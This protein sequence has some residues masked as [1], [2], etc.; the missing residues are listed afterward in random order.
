MLNTAIGL[1]TLLAALL[2]TLAIAGGWLGGRAQA[3][4][5]RALSLAELTYKAELI[6]V[7]VPFEAQSRRHVDGKLLVTDVG[8][9]VERVL[10]GGAKP[11]ESLV[12]TLLGGELDGIALSVPGEATLVLG[13]RALMFLQRAPRSRDL[14]VVGM[15]QGC[16]AMEP[17]ADGTMMVIPGGSGS[18]L[19]ER[20]SDGRLRPAPAALMQPEPADALLSKVRAL[21]AEQAR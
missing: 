9:R 20:N 14:R 7:G 17:A 11:G 6:V 10:E 1:R 8:V 18:A 15:A 4:T 2:C 13:E 19:V 12:V 5:V 21:V 3:S 16:M